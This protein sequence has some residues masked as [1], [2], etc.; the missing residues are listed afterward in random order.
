MSC[1]HLVVTQ[2]VLHNSLDPCLGA[3]SQEHGTHGNVCPSPH[4]NSDVSVL[5]LLQSCLVPL[6]AVSGVP[7]APQCGL[8]PDLGSDG[9]CHQLLG[10]IRDAQNPEGSSWSHVQHSRQCRGVP[11][12]V[13]HTVAASMTH[14]P[15]GPQPSHRGLPEAVR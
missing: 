15:S 13:S 14:V 11:D 1:W 3:E 6:Q 4:S 5:L 7:M 8:H 10:D 12:L 2:H 9:T